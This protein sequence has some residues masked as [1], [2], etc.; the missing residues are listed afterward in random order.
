MRIYLASDHAGVAL[1]EH[2]VHSLTAQGHEVVNMGPMEFTPE[3]DYPDYCRPLAER[4]VSDKGSVGII[5]GYS[6][7]GEA[8]AANRVPGARAV[9]FYGGDE[10]MTQKILE[11]S[12]QHNDA[13]ILSLGSAFLNPSDVE[14][15]VGIWLTMPFSGEE[16]HVRRIAKLG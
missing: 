13:N 2:L 10:I 8:I 6:G 4:V 7:Q 16:R 9:V 11:L 5:A 3:D 15:L 12:R 1:K 14:R